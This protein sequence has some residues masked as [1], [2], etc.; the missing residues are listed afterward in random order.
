V[1]ELIRKGEIHKLKELMKRSGQQGMQTFDQALFRRYKEGKIS[2]EDAAHYADSSN[3]IRLMIKLDEGAQRD[4][5]AVF[6]AELL[7]G[8]N[9]GAVKDVW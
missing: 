9:D 5:A 6:E 2:A 7:G 3:E 8:S 1:S 4:D